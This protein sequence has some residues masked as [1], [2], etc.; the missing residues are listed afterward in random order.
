MTFLFSLLLSGSSAYAFRSQRDIAFEEIFKSID[1]L[2]SIGV[3]GLE[4]LCLP[5]VELEPLIPECTDNHMVSTGFLRNACDKCWQHERGLIRGARLLRSS[6]NKSTGEGIG[7][8]QRKLDYGVDE[9]HDTAFYIIGIGGTILSIIFVALIAGMFLGLLTLDPLDLRIKMQAAVDPAER[10]AAAAIF[11]IVSQNHR[12]LVTL[13]LMNAIAYECLPLFLDRLMPTYLTI[14]FSVTVLLVFGEIIP[15]AIFTGPDQLLLA[16][17]LVTLVKFSMTALHPITTPLVKLMD[18]LVPNN[19][20]D[21][22]EEYNRA[23]LSALVRIQFDERM[24]AQKQRDVENALSERGVLLPL[25]NSKARKRR[26]VQLHH[27]AHQLTAEKQR[28]SEEEYHTRSTRSWRRL[29]EEIM[30][31]AD[32]HLSD[33]QNG[34]DASKHHKDSSGGGIRSLLS[35][36][37]SLNS[38]TSTHAE[39][40]VTRAT[41]QIAPPLEQTEVKVVEGALNLKTMCALDVY[42]PLR[43]IF[44]VPED[45]LLTKEAFAEIYG[46]G[47]SRVPVYESQKPP[48]DHRITSV[49]GV[50]MTRQLIMIDWEHERTVSTLPLYIP[51]CVSPRMNL[52]TLLHLLR[53]GGSLMAFVCAAIPAEAGFMGIVTLQD[54]LESVLQERIYDEEDFAQRHLAS[55]GTLSTHRVNAFSRTLSLN[56]KLKNSVSVLTH[57]AASIIQKFMKKR[58]A[59]RTSFHGPSLPTTGGSI[60]DEESVKSETTPLLKN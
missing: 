47:Y 38:V 2:K 8:G 3:L 43:M 37:P 10:K 52:V 26:S 17:R 34:V 1:T 55:A 30:A 39:Q 21:N 6:L 23:Y 29:K 11:P 53:K 60:V 50:L 25:N 13:L 28:R 57:W 40:T 15:S 19:L 9:A 27:M 4:T 51:P 12:L 16:S 22:E 59:T 36:I 46:Q 5:T 20:N 18:R 44:A 14:I 58:K 7:L 48:N 33:S 54:V 35:R 24:K 31:A 42:T 45:L 32:K 56:C 49:K 41:E